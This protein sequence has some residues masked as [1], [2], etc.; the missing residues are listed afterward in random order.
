VESRTQHLLYDR[1]CGLGGVSSVRVCVILDFEL[2]FPLEMISVEECDNVVSI[3]L[4]FEGNGITIH[5]VERGYE[6]ETLIDNKR[7]G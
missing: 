1:C 6:G 3:G 5:P 4:N 7:R 2:D